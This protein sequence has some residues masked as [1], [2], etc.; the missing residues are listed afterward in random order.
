M[1]RESLST[2]VLTVCRGDD[3]DDDDD[4]TE[5]DL[6]VVAVLIFLSSP[7]LDAVVVRTVGL[8]LVLGLLVVLSRM[9]LGC[10]SWS[11]GG[12]LSSKLTKLGCTSLPPSFESV[13]GL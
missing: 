6:V 7:V 5:V 3:D 2:L 9:L 13:L 10:W 8:V 1:L 4:G 11:L 12:E